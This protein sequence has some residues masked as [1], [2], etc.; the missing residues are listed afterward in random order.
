MI[1]EP[2]STLTYTPYQQ[3]NDTAACHRGILKLAG[4]LSPSNAMAKT[5]AKDIESTTASSDNQGTD[6]GIILIPNPTASPS[7][8]LNWPVYKKLLTLTIVTLAG[9]IGLA[10]TV[11]LNSGYF[12]QA[13]L[14][15]KT[16]VQ[17]SYGVRNSLHFTLLAIPTNT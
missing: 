8:P 3:S 1:Q 9:F 12:I 15:E 2:Q 17:L 5:E 6:N 4:I 10:Q 14:Y 13:K 7:D 11:A 16:P